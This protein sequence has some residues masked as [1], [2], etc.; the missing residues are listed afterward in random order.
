MR[1]RTARLTAIVTVWIAAGV[2]G[3]V[4]FN[5]EK[6]I[7]ATRE[8]LRA[9]DQ[10][11]REVA[12][13]LGDMRAAQQAYVAAGQGAVLWMPRVTA[14]QTE[15]SRWVDDLRAAASSA[16][17]RTALMEAGATINEFGNVDRRARDYLRAGQTLMAGD[18]VFTEGGE[19]ATSA[20]RLVETARL[21]EHQAFG[22]SEARF[23]QQ[24]ATALAVAAGLNVLVLALLA[25]RVP[26]ASADE[27]PGT[28]T[29][30]EKAARPTGEL[31]LRDISRPKPP[32]S[33]PPSSS[34]PR[35]SVPLLKSAADLCTEIG[36]VIDPADLQ[37]LLA[38]LAGMLDASGIVVWLGGVG[39]P[40]L[41]PVLAHGYPDH[42]L[43]RMPNV[44]RSAD[45]AAAA[46][47]RTGKL[48]IVLRRPGASNGAIVAPLLG[49]KGCIG[50]LSAEIL[51][52]G[53][54]TDGVQA[55][56]ALVAAQLASLLAESAA[57]AVE[58]EAPLDRIALA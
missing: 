34:L 19:T 38:R 30:D 7:A 22:A 40:E 56:A 26:Q 52:G 23:R 18:V 48:Q 58:A 47:Y 17:G 41:R 51:G 3:Y 42:I 6:R 15:M 39:G 50:A 44:P 9:F 54:T 21:A 35:S 12:T 24:Q 36:R 49:P 29:I 45:N 28:G 20:A 1:S 2:A 14:L 43:T 31:M 5:T 46:A 13:A 16:G 55:L 53:E 4:L 10:H 11:S 57:I 32:P 8:S 37:G 27:A 33:P 25:F